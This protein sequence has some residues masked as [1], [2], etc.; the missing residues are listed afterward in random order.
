VLAVMPGDDLIGRPG[1]WALPWAPG[2][3]A[4]ARGG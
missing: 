3:A 1:A 4:A 2:G